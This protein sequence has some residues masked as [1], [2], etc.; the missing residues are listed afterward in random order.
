M[1]DEGGAVGI[2]A[3]DDFRRLA[4]DLALRRLPFEVQLVELSGGV[5][6]L[7]PV[8]AR[9]QFDRHCGVGHPTAGIKARREA[10]GNVERRHR[11]ALLDAGHLVKG[12]QPHPAGL[13]EPLQ[14]LAGQRAVL[15]REGH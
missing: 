3:P 1:Q 15:A 13:G 2:V 7:V 4:G 14:P 9:E 10:E 5:A 6:A 8:R 11:L 12:L